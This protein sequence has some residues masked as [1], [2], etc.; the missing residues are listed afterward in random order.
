MKRIILEK[1]IYASGKATFCVLQDHCLH[2]AHLFDLINT[3][4]ISVFNCK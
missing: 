1:R 4:A 3:H 2:L